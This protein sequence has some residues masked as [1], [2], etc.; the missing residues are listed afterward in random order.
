MRTEPEHELLES[1]AAF[2]RCWVEG[3]T[4]DLRRFLHP[5]VVFTGPGFQ[6][7]ARGADAC[8][9]SYES[10]VSAARIHDFTAADYVVDTA[11]DSAVM[12]YRWT[13]DYEMGGDR[14]RESG[15]ELLVWVRRAGRWEIFW[16][17]QQAD[18]G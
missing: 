13:I 6:R 2:D 12:T 16:R 3:R 9:Q 8:V 18:Q 14:H 5:D 1:A 7:L 15:R 17:N 11:G 10:F 4:P